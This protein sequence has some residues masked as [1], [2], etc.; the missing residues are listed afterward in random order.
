MKYGLSGKALGSA[1]IASK[2]HISEDVEKFNVWIDE[3]EDIT[4]KLDIFMQSYKSE[5]ES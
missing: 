4:E 3:T 5:S 2:N 1:I